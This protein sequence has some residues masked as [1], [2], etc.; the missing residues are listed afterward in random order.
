ME[1]EDDFLASI[2]SGVEAED[3]ALSGMGVSVD[4]GGDLPG[5]GALPSDMRETGERNVV[6]QLPGFRITGGPG[7]GV[8]QLPGEAQT[9]EERV[10]E[11]APSAHDVAPGTPAPS[12]PTQ[13]SLDRR[14]AM[15]RVADMLLAGRREP[16]SMPQTMSGRQAATV[17]SLE[18]AIG[19]LRR[20][21]SLSDAAS[22]AMP[23]APREPGTESTPDRRHEAAWVHADPTFGHAD[24]LGALLGG[25]QG[26]TYAERVA[27]PRQIQRQ[28]EEQAPTE[29]ELA[30]VVGSAP[31]MMLPGG[32]RTVM[33]RVAQGAR[34]GAAIGA[35]QAHG[36]S[37]SADFRDQALDTILGAG[38]GGLTGGAL[39]GA[40]EGLGALSRLGRR[41]G[42][43][44]R[45]A[46]EAR[47][48]ASGLNPNPQGNT[49]AGREMARVG[50][51]EGLADELDRFR[52]GGRLP[53][54]ASAGAERARLADESN[55]MLSGIRSRMA[56]EA[57]EV[58]LQPLVDEMRAIAARMGEVPHGPEQAA[59]RS[60]RSQVVDPLV[61][62]LEAGDTTIP[63]TL[64]ERLRTSYG[65]AGRFNSVFST[66][67]Q[68]ARSEGH[69]EAWGVATDAMSDVA[70]RAAPEVRQAWE[71]ARRQGQVGHILDRAREAG[72][73][74]PGS[75]AEGVSLAQGNVPAAV[76]ARVGGSVLSRF[77][78][79]LRARGLQGIAAGLR[80][81]GGEG[82]RFGSMLEAAQ[83][84]RGPAGAAAAHFLMMRTRPGYREAVERARREQEQG[85]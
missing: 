13:P 6:H 9:Y 54:P 82:S 81:L 26:D 41:G 17:G 65:A 42:A 83:R 12:D 62:R 69:R 38:F 84:A 74:L 60:F 44:A 18:H 28:A 61:R 73:R 7:G 47:V 15:E 20:G 39:A 35:L 71:T 37:E 52:V 66:P 79:G 40:G 49:A 50:G 11:K 55:A 31:L 68:S 77:G 51:V 45:A 36:E 46:A 8:E 70:E 10:V 23:T 48:A 85:R 19:T 43:L 27:S 57:G 24:E 32:Q 22:V 25:G 21:G 56:G 59:A 63:W 76:T 64:A 33:G 3:E 16:G 58:A 30:R 67:A 78:P 34:Q 80:A 4:A 75:L 14:P 72:S 53:T 1:D 2:G 5:T 29:A